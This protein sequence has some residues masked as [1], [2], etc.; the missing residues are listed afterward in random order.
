M[1][2][3]GRGG[4]RVP[5]VDL[6][7]AG[8]RGTGGPLLPGAWVRALDD[9]AAGTRSRLFEAALRAVLAAHGEGYRR[10]VC[11]SCGP[12]GLAVAWAAAG[13]GV[14]ATV[15]LPV[16]ATGPA[17]RIAALG[18]R[19]VYGGSTFGEVL[20]SSRALALSSCA[21]VN[22]GGRYEG[23][24]L[25]ALGQSVNV[26][27]AGSAAPPAGI[28]L[29]MGSG[30]TVTAVGRR[31]LAAGWSTAVFAVAVA[32]RHSVLTSWPGQHRPVPPGDFP[33]VSPAAV[34]W[35]MVRE[36][37][38]YGAAA[39]DVLAGTGGMPVGVAGADLLRAQELLARHGV[40]ASAVGS[41]GLA[42]LLLAAAQ[43]RSAAGAPGR[44]AVAGRH[45]V[46]VTG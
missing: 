39:T 33:A 3:A 37:A 4:G 44:A 35:P 18:A 29:P 17:G 13:L 30:A 26:I 38:E 19:V 20:A 24:V 15:V 27:A 6:V 40:R 34:S 2:G 9:A 43:G 10:V 1:P 11:G 16:D 14:E 25:D 28:W 22:V 21:D 32:G 12:F 41:A 5:L 42:G 31:V 36:T 7:A 8:T 46:V 45:V 23:Q